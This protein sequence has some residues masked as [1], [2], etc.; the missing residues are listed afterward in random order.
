MAFLSTVSR[1]NWNLEMLAFVEGGQPEYSVPEKN[2]WSRDEKQQQTQP[3]YDAESGNRTRATL[4]ECSHHCA[5]SIQFNSILFTLITTKYN[6]F[7]VRKKLNVQS[8]YLMILLS[9]E[10]VR[11]GQRSKAFCSPITFKSRE[12]VI[13]EFK[14]NN[15]L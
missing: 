12:T 10:E 8:I 3:I 4:V 2:P 13:A 6:I 15:A 9:T 1:S 14:A 5:N 7:T 11:S